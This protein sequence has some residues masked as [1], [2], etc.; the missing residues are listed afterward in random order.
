MYASLIEPDATLFQR[1]DVRSAIA[2]RTY[3]AT[4]ALRAALSEDG[5]AINGFYTRFVCEERTTAP[6]SLQVRTL[7]LMLRHCLCLNLLVS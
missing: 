5:R 7:G 1:R 2:I 3:I 6:T 4:T